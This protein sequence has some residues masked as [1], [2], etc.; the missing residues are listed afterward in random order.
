MRHVEFTALVNLTQVI[1]PERN[2]HELGSTGM[3]T[4]V[5]FCFVLQLEH[6]E[7]EA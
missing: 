7:N 4:V 2:V 1:L 3:Y 5:G 6:R